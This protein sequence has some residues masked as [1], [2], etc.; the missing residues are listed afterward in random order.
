MGLGDRAVPDGLRGHQG[1]VLHADA[2]CGEELHQQIGA[3]PLQQPGGGEQAQV[4]RA[5]QF[6]LIVPAHVQLAGELQLP[7]P[8]EIQQA[9]DLRHIGVDGS[10]GIAPVHQSLAPAGDGVPADTPVLRQHEAE[11]GEIPAVLLQRSLPAA[12]MGQ[13]LQKVVN[14]PLGQFK[15]GLQPGTLCQGD[16]LLSDRDICAVGSAFGGAA[17]SALPSPGEEG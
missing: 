3:L 2:S 14:L 7:V 8:Q 5:G 17:E 10:G 12:L 9:V 15:A 16:R 1:H 6:R 13:M 4:L 11:A